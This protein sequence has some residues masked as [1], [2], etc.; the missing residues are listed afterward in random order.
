MNEYLDLPKDFVCPKCGCDEF[1]D[2]GGITSDGESI[3]ECENCGH[4]IFGMD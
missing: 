2:T 1:K 4:I 3:Y